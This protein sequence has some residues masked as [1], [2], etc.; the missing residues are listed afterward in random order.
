MCFKIC[1]TSASVLKFEILPWCEPIPQ[2][3]GNICKKIKW[4]ATDL[5]VNVN[6]C[7]QICKLA[8]K[9]AQRGINLAFTAATKW[10]LCIFLCD[11]KWCRYI[12]QILKY[13]C[14]YSRK[15]DFHMQSQYLIPILRYKEKTFEI[16]RKTGH[17]KLVLC[18]FEPRNPIS[19]MCLIYCIALRLTEMTEIGIACL[20]ISPKYPKIPKIEIS[21]IN[22]R[23]KLIHTWFE[24]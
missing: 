12:L 6:D 16:P 1:Q 14:L 7:C 11:A 22:D 23:M 8:T 19:Y 10:D 3:K 9:R 5:H 18:S 4:N 13:V 15:I 21:G 24:S 2:I 17:T 20:K